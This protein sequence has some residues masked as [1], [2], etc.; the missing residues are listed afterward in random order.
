LA[1]AVAPHGASPLPAPRRVDPGAQEAAQHPFRVADQAHQV[2]GEDRVF[3]ILVHGGFADEAR[4]VR[5]VE[6]DVPLLQ[7]ER[8]QAADALVDVL[9]VGHVDP[10]FLDVRHAQDG[11]A[12]LGVTVRAMGGAV[13][14]AG[15]EVVQGHEGP[16]LRDLGNLQRLGD[17]PFGV[18]AEAGGLAL[19]VSHPPVLGDAAREGVGQHRL[20]EALE[21]GRQLRHAC[22][23]LAG[24]RQQL[25]GLGHDAA[26]LGQGRQGQGDASQERPEVEV[27]DVRGLRLPGV[28]LAPLV[29]VAE[30]ERHVGRV[31]VRMEADLAAEVGADQRVPGLLHRLLVDQQAAADGL[32]GAA[33]GNLDDQVAGPELAPL[34]ARAGDGPLGGGPSL[35]FIPFLELGA[36]QDAHA[37]IAGREVPVARDAPLAA[38]GMN[39]QLLQDYFRPAL[40]KLTFNLFRI[41]ERARHSALRRITGDSSSVSPS[42]SLRISLRSPTAPSS[43]A[44]TSAAISSG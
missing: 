2:G 8:L 5:A 42:S 3:F 9:E 21:S 31:H 23:H 37:D 4:A 18:V 33:A 38:E 12:G 7:P 24:L 30:H 44:M 25:S 26:L 6:E 29:A 15:D 28:E 36:A 1:H 35:L 17:L 34:E 43:S 27:A 16:A 14:D 10:A 13:L 20:A 39:H 19:A 22:P 32:V 40:P 41:V 11:H